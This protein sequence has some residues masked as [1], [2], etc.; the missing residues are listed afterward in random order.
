[1]KEQASLLGKK[2]QNI[3]IGEVKSSIDDSI[4]SIK[5]PQQRVSFYKASGLV[6][7]ENSLR[8]MHRFNIATPA[9]GGYTYHLFSITHGISDYPLNLFIDEDVSSELGYNQGKLTIESEEE[10]LQI[11]SK[12]LKAERTKQIVQTLL[13]QS[14]DYNI[15]NFL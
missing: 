7:I 10:F 2:T 8:I 13:A 12:I 3:V 5:L 9:L 6:N 1:M 11:L 4:D 14:M 15:E